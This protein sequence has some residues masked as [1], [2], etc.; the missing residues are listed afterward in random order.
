M[1]RNWFNQPEIISYKPGR[2]G[3]GKVFATLRRLAGLP[4]KSVLILPDGTQYFSEAL[5]A[6]AATPYEKIYEREGLAYLESLLD[7]HIQQYGNR[8]LH[9]AI[10]AYF[11]KRDAAIKSA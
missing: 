3:S 2:K 5:V 11:K 1:P 6:D 7:K 8:E 4:D 10:R 9:E